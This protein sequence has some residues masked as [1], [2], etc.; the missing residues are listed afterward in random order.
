LAIEHGL[1]QTLSS[2]SILGDTSYGECCVDEVAAEHIGADGV[3]HFGNT[4]LTPTQ[5][6]PVL[7]IF[8]VLPLNISS[9]RDK[10]LTNFKDVDKKVALVYDV[11]Y[12]NSILELKCQSVVICQPH[13]PALSADTDTEETEDKF[14]ECG[15]VWPQD[16]KLNK[17][18]WIIVCV[19][20]NDNFASLI[21]FTFN[22]WTRPAGDCLF[23]DHLTRQ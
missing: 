4:C 16:I 12:H 23:L 22:Q 17:D 21:S 2:V 14:I 19:G 18:H 11:P 20:N 7:Y 6:L 5:R 9:L 3:I 1:G 13:Q 10:L 15:R 8:T